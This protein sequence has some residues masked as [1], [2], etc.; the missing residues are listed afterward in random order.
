MKTLRTTGG[1]Q[2]SLNWT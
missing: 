1:G 2:D